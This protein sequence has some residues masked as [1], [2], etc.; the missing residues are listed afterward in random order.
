MDIYLT[1]ERMLSKLKPIKVQKILC[2]FMLKLDNML[3][4]QKLSDFIKSASGI[5]TRKNQFLLSLNKI[6]SISSIFFI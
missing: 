3:F 5:M 1:N 4:V 6:W 2:T